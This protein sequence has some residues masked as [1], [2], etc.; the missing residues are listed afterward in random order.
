[1]PET[2]NHKPNLL[3]PLLIAIF[4]CPLLAEQKSPKSWERTGPL[5]PTPRHA[6]DDYP[7]CDQANKAGWVKYAPMTDEFD[8]AKLD[9]EKWWPKNPSWLGRKPAWFDPANVK[10]A[11]SKLHL[12]MKKNEPAAMPKD[13]GYHTYTS[14]AV[15]SKGLVKY[16]YFEVRCR[17]M[18]SAGSSSFWFYHQTPDL[19]TEIDVFEIGG[20]APK[21]EK[22]YNMNVHVFKTPT[23][24]KHWSKGGKWLAPTNLA[25]AYHSY[26]LEW[27]AEKIKWYFDGVLVR[28]VE[29]THWH[30]PLTLNF[31]S[32]TMPDWFGLPKDEDLPSTYSI[33]YVR[34]W[35]TRNQILTSGQ[36]I[37]EIFGAKGKNAATA[38]QAAMYKR[39]F[40]RMDRDGDKKISQADYVEK[41]PYMT[42]EARKHI[43][44]A[45]DSNADGI[46]TE[47]EYID[48]RAITD[49]AKAIYEKMDDNRDAALTKQ[50]FLGNTTIKDKTLAQKIFQKLDANHNDELNIPEYLRTWGKWARQPAFP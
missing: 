45:S 26:A 17:P 50:E 36:L 37:L 8:G 5:G 11:D 4:A 46:L 9:S 3:L 25:D 13:K 1:M 21:F 12:S 19:W 6:T 18:A 2:T 42:K 40:T 39:I 24:K 35:K 43:F 33:E 47:Q 7:L 30:Q 29:N 14:A 32:E 20:A 28:W 10:V 49:E 38:N 22:K 15:Q 34:A 31:D 48:N 27:D 44:A 16:G 41:S 23:E